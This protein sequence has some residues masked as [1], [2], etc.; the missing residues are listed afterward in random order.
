MMFG[1]IAWYIYQYKDGKI[2]YYKET[3]TNGLRF[4]T[5]NENNKCFFLSE[6]DATEAWNRL[7]KIGNVESVCV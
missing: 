7:G 1:L 2:Y 4:W 5:A 3:H 6:E